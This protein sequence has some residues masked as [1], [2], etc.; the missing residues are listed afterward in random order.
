MI[1]TTAV[2][3]GSSQPPPGLP[4]ARVYAVVA[5]CGLVPV[6]V[7]TAAGAVEGAVAAAGT[8]VALAGTAGGAVPWCLPKMRSM[9]CRKIMQRPVSDSA[10]PGRAM[11]D[12]KEG[13]MG[14]A[15]AGGSGRGG[16]RGGLHDGGQSGHAPRW[17]ATSY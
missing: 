10:R 7:P 6:K 8:S 15:K 4:G 11:V 17:R 16:A 13:A 5:C 9:A 1:Y 12:C 2:G 3:V 14:R